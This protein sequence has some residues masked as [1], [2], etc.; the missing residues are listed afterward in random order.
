MHS[1]VLLLDPP[2]CLAL[3][4]DAGRLSPQPLYF[5]PEQRLG[6]D[7][8]AILVFFTKIQLNGK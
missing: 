8:C 7:K 3:T 2:V 1:F 5:E 4:S 6:I